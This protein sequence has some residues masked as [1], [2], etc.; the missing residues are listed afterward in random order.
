[1]PTVFSPYRICPIGAHVDHQHGPVLGMAIAHGTTLAFEP[2]ADA[3]CTLSSA[4][5]PEVARFDVDRVEPAGCPDWTRYPRAAA[6][7]LRGR[8]PARP[9]GIVGCIEGALAGGGLSSSASLLLACLHALA[10]ANDLVLTPEQQVRGSLAAENDFV[11]LRSGVLDPAAIV[12]SRRGRIVA[13]DTRRLRWETLAP[14]PG[15]PPYRVVVAFSGLTRN[16]LAT[17]FNERV[18]E[19][20]TAAGLLAQRAGLAPALRLGDLPEAVFETHL[21]ALPPVLQRRARHFHEERAR[22]RAGIARWR[23]G[24]LAAFGTLMNESC[25]SSIVH[26]ETGSAEL[27]SLHELLLEG[28]AFGSRFS[29]AGFA[30]CAIALVSA[31]RAEACRR[32]VQ[33]GF[34][35]RH[36]EHADAARVFLTDGDDG[37]RFL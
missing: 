26:F 21:D 34:A 32:H 1:M 30:G 8:L 9:R 22:V 2:S 12:A 3:R 14:G 19:C 11:G 13:I 27:V 31:E 6:W 36:P 33:E 18:A 25:H 16:L 7:A 37:V 17:G 24:D 29:G 4:D 35:R 20:G 28:G 15:A 5:F 10:I 23:E